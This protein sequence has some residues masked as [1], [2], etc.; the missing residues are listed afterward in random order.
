MTGLNLL[1]I[2]FVP[3]CLGIALPRTGTVCQPE[4]SACMLWGSHMNNNTWLVTNKQGGFSQQDGFSHGNLRNI[5]A[6][7]LIT[8]F[9][10]GRVVLDYTTVLQCFYNPSSDGI[11]ANSD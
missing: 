5:A 4:A 7:S 8:V 3:A 2:N 11:P 1:F 9:I 10:I 6:P